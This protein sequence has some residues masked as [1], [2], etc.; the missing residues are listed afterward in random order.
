MPMGQQWRE[1]GKDLLEWGAKGLKKSGA[2]PKGLKPIRSK[3]L[4]R[5]HKV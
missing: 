5:T 4:K 1:E 2:H 3:A